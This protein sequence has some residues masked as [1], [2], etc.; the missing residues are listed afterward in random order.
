MPVYIIEL[1]KFKPLLKIP[2]C[3]PQLNRF[4]KNRS[5]SCII[6]R[7]D[8]TAKKSSLSTKYLKSNPLKILNKYPYQEVIEYIKQQKQYG[9]SS[10]NI[11]NSWNECEG[12]KHEVAAENFE[13]KIS[14]LLGK[15]PIRK[16]CSGENLNKIYLKNKLIFYRKK[17]IAE[18]SDLSQP[19][20]ANHNKMYQS[21]LSINPTLF[22]R[23]NGE[24]TIHCN[25][26]TKAGLNCFKYS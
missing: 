25:A 17:R 12:P 15:Y 23:I 3:L 9:Q 8:P 11:Q 6:N 14:L 5:V 4:A 18:Y 7:Y 24:F 2:N 13:S 26:M 16:S 1:I 10:E 20:A 22:R 19:L 21:K